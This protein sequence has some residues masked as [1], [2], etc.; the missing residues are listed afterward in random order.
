M[1]TGDFAATAALP[2]MAPGRAE[3]GDVIQRRLPPLA[4]ESGEIADGYRVSPDRRRGAGEL[5]GNTSRRPGAVG[6][7]PHGA[8]WPPAD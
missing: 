7:A 4:A 8:G 3:S 5:L 2:A 1:V 6:S